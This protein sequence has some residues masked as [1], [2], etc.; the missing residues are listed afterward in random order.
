MSIREPLV[1]RKAKAEIRDQKGVN[2]H[3]QAVLLEG[4]GLPL[5]SRAH[6]PV[7][8]SRV[9]YQVINSYGIDLSRFLLVAHY[10]IK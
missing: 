2:Y 9:A 4:V 3:F 1:K 5:Q 7:G 10:L 6:S 8:S